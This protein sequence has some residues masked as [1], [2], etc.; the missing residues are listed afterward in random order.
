MWAWRSVL[1]VS[2]VCGLA[3]DSNN[4]RS[5]KE[6][7][8]RS[9]E[10][11]RSHGDQ[12]EGTA[13][14]RTET[15]S[16]SNRRS[17]AACSTPDCNAPVTGGCSNRAQRRLSSQDR[18]VDRQVDRER[19]TDSFNRTKAPEM[20]SCVRSGDCAD[21]LCCVR[22]LTGRRCQRIPTQGDACLLLRGSGKVRG[23]K[24]GRCPCDTGLSCTATGDRAESGKNKSQGVCQPRPP[25]G[26]RKTR[27]SGKKRR[28]VERSC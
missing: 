16:N 8:D 7:A 2:V 10:P 11:E 15:N 28:T 4:I 3:L 14:R 19:D 22:Y 13:R 6:A 1:C 24:L 20:S 26:Q 18:Q 23:R 9:A 17:T 25:Q 12:V 27:H 5:S 21:G